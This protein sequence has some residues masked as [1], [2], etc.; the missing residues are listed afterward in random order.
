MLV[1]NSCTLKYHRASPLPSSYLSKYRFEFSSPC[2]CQSVILVA[3]APW[4]FLQETSLSEDPTQSLLQ[5]RRHPIQL[6]ELGLSASGRA[7][8]TR[9]WSEGPYASRFW[10]PKCPAT[11]CTSYYSPAATPGGLVLSPRTSPTFH[12]AWSCRTD[13]P[14]ASLQ[15]I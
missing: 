7:A 14:S 10:T 4:E 12:W 5:Q 3:L 13:P 2:F 8:A 11:P 9:S 1:L 15:H 6:Y